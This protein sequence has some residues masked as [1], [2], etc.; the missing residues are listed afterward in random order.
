MTVPATKETKSPLGYDGTLNCVM[1]VSDLDRSIAWYEGVLGF[2]LLYRM[3][4]MTWCELATET[5][6]VN[7]GLGQSETVEQGGGALSLGVKD[8]ESA[9]AFIEARGVVFD[10]PTMD[11]EGMV[12][13]AMFKDPDGNALMLFQRLEG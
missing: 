13:L 1:S 12:K 5:P 2:S 6:G 11:I 3:E 9:R 7:V 8:I 10:G 4:G